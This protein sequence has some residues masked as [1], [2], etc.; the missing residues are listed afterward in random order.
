MNPPPKPSPAIE[1]IARGVCLVEDHLLLC[2]S[3]KAG[4]LYLPGGHVE[5][6]EKAATALVREMREELGMK[7]RVGEFLGCVEH[8]FRQAGQ[9]HAEINLVFSMH[10]PRLAPRTTPVSIED[11]IA[12]EWLPIDRLRQSKLQ[13]AV[14]RRCLPSW[15]RPDGVKRLASTRDGWRRA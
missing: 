14:L 5:F 12:F 6:G 3:R 1:T 10:S 4:N 8:V 11:W 7:V 2:R 13:P 15:L 9:R